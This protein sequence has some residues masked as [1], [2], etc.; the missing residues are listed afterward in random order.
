[1]E[2]KKARRDK[3]ELVHRLMCSLDGARPRRDSPILCCA[4]SDADIAGMLWSL[5]IKRVIQTRNGRVESD[6]P[7]VPA[8]AGTGI[9]ALRIEESLRGVGD[10]GWRMDGVG[11]SVGCRAEAESEFRMME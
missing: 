4:K 2:P 11:W 9:A 5:Q 8:G 7:V 6:T 3:D 1:M 10:G